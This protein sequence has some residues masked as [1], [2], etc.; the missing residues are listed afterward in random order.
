M[1][2]SSSSILAR[3]RKRCN[4]PG[5]IEAISSSRSCWI[6]ESDM[7]ARCRRF[8]SAMDFLS[9]GAGAGGASSFNV[10]PCSC[11]ARRCLKEEGLLRRR[12]AGNP[13]E[14]AVGVGAGGVA[15]EGSL[16][17]ISPIRSNGEGAD[18]SGGVSSSRSKTKR[19]PRNAMVRRAKDEEVMSARGLRLPK[20]KWS[21]R[22]LTRLG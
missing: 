10:S 1:I 14:E 7:D 21:C 13:V 12:C 5:S 6:C 2:C 9:S 22:R 16:S 8:S 18:S 19:S 17:R 15:A 3:R 11:C 4:S 20:L